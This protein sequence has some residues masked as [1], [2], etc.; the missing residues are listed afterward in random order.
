M[1]TFP[2][3]SSPF[4]LFS[5]FIV[6]FNPTFLIKTMFLTVFSLCFSCC[7]T[8][9]HTH[10]HTHTCWINPSLWL[11]VRLV[12]LKQIYH[13][14]S[15][16]TCPHLSFYTSCH[17]SFTFLLINTSS[18]HPSIYPRHYFNP[19]PLHPFLD[20]PVCE[21][22]LHLYRHLLTEWL[23]SLFSLA[24]PPMFSYWLDL[25]SKCL[26]TGAVTPPSIFLLSLS[27]Y[28]VSVC[29]CVISQMSRSQHH[30]T[31]QQITHFSFLPRSLLSALVLMLES[32]V[33]F[34]SYQFMNFHILQVH[35]NA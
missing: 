27:I 6:S 2:L 12:H 11:V 17:L 23:S 21:H 31:L 34:L 5:S 1:E 13:S 24:A 19:V 18:I 26:P 3:P 14:R 35:F 20:L 25:P 28:R 30:D 7:S 4:P 10:K 15:D 9:T 8:R 22:S 29:V 32:S 33:Y 16:F